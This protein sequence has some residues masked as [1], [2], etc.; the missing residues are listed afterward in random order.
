MNLFE[1]VGNVI[2]DLRQAYNNG[3]GMSQQA[4]A[5]QLSVATNTV[6]RWETA[7][8]KPTL[9]DLES[10]AKFFSVKIL[11]FFPGEDI[12][13]NKVAALLRAAKQLSPNDLEELQRYAEFRKA[14]HLYESG[15]RPARGRKKA[16]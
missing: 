8:Y 1:Y 13:D 12:A 4:L 7:T 14:R 2:R 6:S 10:L 11:K 3:E 16:K 9:E 15:S 5:E